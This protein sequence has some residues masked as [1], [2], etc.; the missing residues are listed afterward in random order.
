MIIGSFLL[1]LYV[2]PWVE[3]P[4]HTSEA[5][6]Q[7]QQEDAPALPAA[8]LP[9]KNF[10]FETVVEGIS[11]THDFIIQN[12]GKAPLLIHKVKTG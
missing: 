3:T 12:K 6:A 11:V 7:A 1:F 10:E 2:A 8:F 9:S 4:F 5:Y